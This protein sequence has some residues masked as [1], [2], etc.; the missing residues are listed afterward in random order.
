[1]KRSTR[2]LRNLAEL[3][4]RTRAGVAISE[5]VQART[6]GALRPYWLQTKVILEYVYYFHQKYTYYVTDLR[7]KSDVY[8]YV[9]VVITDMKLCFNRD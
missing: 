9:R 3:H 6:C 2:M 4:T 8:Q 1:M 5:F 7:H